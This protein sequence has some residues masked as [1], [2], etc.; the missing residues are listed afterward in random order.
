MTTKESVHAQLK[1]VEAARSF[2]LAG[3][4]IFTLQSCKTGARYTYK[5]HKADEEPGKAPTWFVSLLT[6]PDNLGDYQYLGLISATQSFRISED[7]QGSTV[8]TLQFRLTKKSRL[9]ITSL[10]VLAFRWVFEKLRAGIEP[11]GVEIWHAGRCGRCG[12][13]LTVPESIELGLGP[14]CASK[15]F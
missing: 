3:N 12:R 13:V 15:M 5:I 9:P 2:M 14:E 4:A 1:G 11:V 7:G 10:P 8:Q 6:G